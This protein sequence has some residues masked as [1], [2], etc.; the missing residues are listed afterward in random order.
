I[1]RLVRKVMLQCD[2]IQCDAQ[3]VKEKI[4]RDYAVDDSKVTVFPWGIDLSLFK[5]ADKNESRAQCN[6][7]IA[8]FIVIFNRSLES[9]YG[10]NDLL[11]GF[12]RFSENK[13]DVMLLILASGS[14]KES[15]VRY[16]QK[17]NLT[18]KVRMMDRITNSLLPAYLNSSDVY[19]STALSDGTSLAMLEAL[20]CGLPLIVTDVPAI[21]EWVSDSNG[22]I[23]PLQSPGKVCEALEKYYG[24]RKLMEEHGEINMKVAKER[25]DWDINY[26]K[27]KEIYNKMTA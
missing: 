16:I 19:I 26:L 2:H 24:N 8:K 7:P 20:A 1:R 15:V 5:T 22:I 9:V 3:F 10:V 6:L 23:V 11:E 12:K 14:Q 13:D 18:A 27:L 25:A 21:R 4:K 17:N